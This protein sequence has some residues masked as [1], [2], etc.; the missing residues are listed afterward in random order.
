MLSILP[1]HHAYEMTCDIWTTF[2]Q[3]KTIAICEGLRYI[4]K[5]MAEVHANVMLGVPL[6]FE[7]MYKGMFKQA[8]ARGEGD[9]LRNAIAL[10]KRLKLYNNKPVVKR[11]FKAIHQSF[12]GDMQKFVAGGA[13][14]DPKV[15]EDFEAMGFTMIQG[16]GMSENAPI[17]AVNQDR[18]SKAESV[19]LPMPH[20]EVRIIN[21]DEDGVGEIICKGPSV[22]LGYYE[23]PEATEEV[24]HNGWLYT[25]DLGYMDEKGYLYITGRK[26]TVIVTKGGKNIFPEEVEAVLLEDEL[27]QEVLVHGVTDD[28]VGNVMI[29]ADIY[30]N[31]KLLK[32]QKGEMNSIGNLPLL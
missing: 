17:I 3:G 29:T 13:A 30:P 9:K 16:Y 24:L 27:I 31:Y 26:K 1:V 7:K 6:V 8:E 12:G 23:N 4:Q 14:I 10:S 25:G 22:M 5:N 20:T 18:Y 21:S 28:R 19:G 11:M 32:E 15:I 2:Y